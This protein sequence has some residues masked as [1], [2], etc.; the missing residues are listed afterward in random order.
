MIQ[1]DI[2]A[3]TQRTVNE[4]VLYQSRNGSTEKVAKAIAAAANTKAHNLS[5]PFDYAALQDG[6][7]V[8]V[9]GGVYAGNCDASVQQCMAELAQT[10]KKLTVALF[11][12]SMK[13]HAAGPVMKAAARD[14]KLDVCAEV[15]DC[16]GKFLLFNRN[17]PDT[18]DLVNATM[19][20]ERI[21]AHAG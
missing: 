2:A 5:T 10:G 1:C 9:G 4:M 8:F 3:S 21:V 13:R 18:Q 16:Q 19:F 11:G 15:F 6:D 20:A 7:I 14:A 17:N 12:S